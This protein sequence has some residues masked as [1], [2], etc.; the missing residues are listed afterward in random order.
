M[1]DYIKGQLAEL[2]PAKAVIEAAG[3]GYE[4]NISLSSYDELRVKSQESRVESQESKLYVYED[5][6]ED[7]WVLFGFA[8]KEERELFLLLITVSG[9]G[10]NTARTILSA[11]PAPE[12]AAIIADGFD[13]LNR[14]SNIT[15]VITSQ[16]RT[17]NYR[18][19]L[20]RYIMLHLICRLSHKPR[21]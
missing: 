18:N 1:I 8:T 20:P 2:T 16:G 4:L 17:E 9:V 7:A 10:G 3:V 14:L 12:L 21:P 6:R 11:Y 15:T 5:I 13:I 19:S